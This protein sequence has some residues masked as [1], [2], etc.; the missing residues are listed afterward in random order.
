[1]QHSRVTAFIEVEVAVQEQMAEAFQGFLD[2]L[3]IQGVAIFDSE[4][5][6]VS[7]SDVEN[8][9]PVKRKKS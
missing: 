1:M 9:D 6:C 3:A 2:S 7:V 5:S 4:I 8:S